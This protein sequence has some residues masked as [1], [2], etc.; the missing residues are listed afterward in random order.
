MTSFLFNPNLNVVCATE[1]Y[2]E[3]FRTIRCMVWA[4]I[5]RQGA[6]CGHLSEAWS[7]PEI[8]LQKSTQIL[9]RE[10][11]LPHAPFSHDGVHAV[12]LQ[13]QWM[14]RNDP[15]LDTQSGD[16]PLLDTPSISSTNVMTVH[17]HHCLARKKTVFFFFG[18]YIREF[19][20]LI[21]SQSYESRALFLENVLRRLSRKIYL[22][23]VC[24]RRCASRS[25]RR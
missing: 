13:K 21:D 11:V 24:I 25:Q 16:E 5:S 18:S 19:Y 8:I 23:V 3:S 12:V 14:V 1:Q 17:R 15:K 10:L 22:Y 2:M 7:P 20:I 9:V 6:V 4:R